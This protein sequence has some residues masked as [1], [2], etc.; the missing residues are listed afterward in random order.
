MSIPGTRDFHHGLLDEL[1]NAG[2]PLRVIGP[3]QSFGQAMID[4]LS[5]ETFALK[6]DS[7]QE[8]FVSQFRPLLS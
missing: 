4:G 7:A 6:L 1:L 3:D 8:P 2:A 5:I